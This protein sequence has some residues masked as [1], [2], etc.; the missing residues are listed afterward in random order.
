MRLTVK[1]VYWQRRFRHETAALQQI[2][3]T[4]R[5]AGIKAMKSGNNCCRDF[6]LGI[7]GFL[8]KIPVQ[9]ERAEK[10]ERQDCRLRR[11]EELERANA[12][13]DKEDESIAS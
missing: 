5:P 2:A 13:Q 11:M 9:D 10:I 1:N 7:L 6:S 3:S 12:V 4:R 8:I